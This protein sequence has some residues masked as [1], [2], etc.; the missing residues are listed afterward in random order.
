MPQPK[1]IFIVGNSRSGTTMMSRILGKHST[2]FSFNELQFLEHII[3]PEQICSSAKIKKAEAAILYSHLAFAQRDGVFSKEKR[4]K[5]LDE[6]NEMITEDSL[7]A[8]EVFQLF[9]TNEC[10]KYSKKI[11]CEQT[12]KNLYY[13]EEITNTVPNVRIINMV[14]D[15]RDVML[16]QKLRWKRRYLGASNVPFIRETLRSWLNYHPITMA[17]LW[18]SAVKVTDRF[19][20]DSRFMS[21][22][23]EAL[24]K[25]PK[26]EI[27]K[28]CHFLNIQFEPEMMLIPNVGSSTEFDKS[29][30]LGID[31]SKQGKWERG[32]LTTTELS[33]C[34]H[35]A[36]K[37]M[38]QHGY[39]LSDVQL[40]KPKWVWSWI[41]CIGKMS[42]ALILNLKR[43]KN[44]YTSIKRRFFS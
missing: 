35:I 33:I 9:C 2:I 17:K 8:I 43:T 3:S 5:Y 19:T 29:N 21:I 30:K 38:Q 25:D 40:S 39:N 23:F 20:D 24:L 11:A 7:T 15:P 42:F 32:G 4:D 37:Q 28:I 16:S 44:I 18:Q 27:S 31:T 14:R 22:Y 13:L 36:G 6:A 41:T 1:F 34:Q 12:P 26:Q 10:K